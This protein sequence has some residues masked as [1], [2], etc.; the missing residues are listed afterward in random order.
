MSSWS[1]LCSQ[2]PFLLRAAIV[3]YSHHR[4]GG[5]GG[6]SSVPHLR[7][8]GISLVLITQALV[9]QPSE[10]L[11]T[12]SVYSYSDTYCQS[13][14]DTGTLDHLHTHGALGSPLRGWSAACSSEVKEK[15][16]PNA[17]PMEERCL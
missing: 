8:H 16:S 14:K 2:L 1:F 7:Q 5:Q 12:C 10:A 13:L 17:K 4:G 11:A 15:A 6:S 3:I 9:S